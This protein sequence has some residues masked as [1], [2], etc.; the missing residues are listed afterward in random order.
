MCALVWAL[1]VIFLALVSVVVGM[2]LHFRDR[3]IGDG[4]LG[5]GLTMLAL[6]GLALLVLA[7]WMVVL[8]VFLARHP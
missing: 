1:P 6:G 5:I 4:G 2:A 7:S 3:E 8:M